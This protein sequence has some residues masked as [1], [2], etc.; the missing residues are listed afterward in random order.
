MRTKDSIKLSIVVPT[1]GR[2][3]YLKDLLTDLAKFSKVERC[4]VVVIDNTSIDATPKVL[5]QFID[6]PHFRFQRNRFNLGIEGNIITALSV[7]CGEYIWLLS[8]HMRIDHDGVKNL[9]H[10]LENLGDFQ[11]GY[12]RIQD[13]GSVTACSAPIELGKLSI[14]QRAKLIFYTSNIS[15]LIVSSV[16]IRSS[17]RSIY[18]MAHYTYPHLGVYFQ[19]KNSDRV[20]EFSTCSSFQKVDRA[21][22]A[23]SYD[24]FRARFID[25]PAMLKELG[26]EN[27]AFDVAKKYTVIK[28]YTSALHWELAKRTLDNDRVITIKE[29]RRCFALYPVSY[30]FVFLAVWLAG[31]LSKSIRRKIV[32]MVAEKVSPKKYEQIVSHISGQGN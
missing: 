22:Y 11:V 26:S 4:E 17:I 7:A 9:L 19:L 24:T 6:T 15:G 29:L 13:Y 23:I 27:S 2:A 28:E 16:L 12:A 1:Y 10:D 21:S 5:D 31:F 30:K 8:D 3:E 14:E 18:R 20:V 25:Y 32:L